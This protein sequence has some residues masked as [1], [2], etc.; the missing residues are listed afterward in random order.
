MSGY[1]DVKEHFT[2]TLSRDIRDM[3]LGDAMGYGTFRHVFNHAT[4]PDAVV[5]LENGAQSFHNIAEWQVW[6][7]VKDTELAKWFA[8]C[9]SISAS[10]TVLVM[11]RAKPVSVDELPKLVPVF[12]TDLKAENWGLIGKRYVCVDYGLHL[13]HERGMTKRM[14]RAY[15]T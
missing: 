6:Q 7:S 3:F 5:K 12:F 4:N 14:R 10:G 9:I 15:W 8:P 13:L 2:T 11:Q 1:V